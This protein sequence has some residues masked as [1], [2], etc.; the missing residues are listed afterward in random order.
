MKFKGALILV[1]ILLSNIC[2]YSQQLKLGVKADF[3][4]GNKYINYQVGPAV[5]LDYS[6]SQ[7]PFSVQGTVRFS[8]GEL[9]NE[10]QFS[11]GY[12]F[13]VFSAGLS[14][15]YYPVV[16]PIEP[17]LSAGVFFNSNSFQ[18]SGT[19]SE[20]FSGNMYFLTGL[21]NN[22]SGELTF[23]IKFSANTP[24]NFI[25]EVTQTFNKPDYTLKTLN[26]QNGTY[27]EI[28]RK[29]K[30]NFNS[31]FLKLGLLFNI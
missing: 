9:S 4:T 16:W 26:S 27:R 31:M 12:A 2:I 28:T 3:L 14:L 25:A 15:N 6:L 8:L 21:K 11:T 13:T 18:E 22:I 30:F 5:A 20:D 1:I 19:P 23:G 17:Y 7:I 29:E 24:V 10:N